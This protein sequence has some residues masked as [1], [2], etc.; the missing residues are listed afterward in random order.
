[1]VE[2]R[3]SKFW[4]IT[5]NFLSV[6]IFRKIT[7]PTIPI[8]LNHA[9]NWCLAFPFMLKLPHLTYWC[10]FGV[11]CQTDVKIIKKRCR[12]AARESSSHAAMKDNMS[13]NWYDQWKCKKNISVQTSQSFVILIVILNT[14]PWQQSPSSV[15][16]HAGRK[17]LPSLPHTH[18]GHRR[19]SDGE[20]CILHSPERQHKVIGYKKERYTVNILNICTVKS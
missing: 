8:L 13:L 6:R 1:M 5:T 9:W 4:V 3:S 10:N 19:G 14:L 18:A 20:Y 7:V 16:W 2:P 17:L 11:K 15:L 12:S